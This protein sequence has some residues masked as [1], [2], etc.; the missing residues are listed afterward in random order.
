MRILDCGPGIWGLPNGPPRPVRNPQIPDPQSK[1]QNHFPFHLLRAKS[2]PATAWV[3][4][5]LVRG[6][7]RRPSSASRETPP[8]PRGRWNHEVTKDT[9]RGR[10]VSQRVSGAERQMSFP[11][12]RLRRLRYFARLLPIS[13]CVVPLQN[14]PSSPLS[15]PLNSRKARRAVRS[16]GSILP[17]V[18]LSNW[19]II[20]ST[21]SRELARGSS[22]ARS[23]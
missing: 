16:S 22:C 1:T 18:F 15:R 5:D 23:M 12:L 19:V 20:F 6:R 8:T 17:F 21:R 13:R 14:P 4:P 9:K 7:A 2:A 10:A 11:I 3:Q